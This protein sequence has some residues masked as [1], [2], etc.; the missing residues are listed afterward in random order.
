MSKDDQIDS[1]SAP[2]LYGGGNV[3]DITVCHLPYQKA[4]FVHGWIY[5]CDGRRDV[6]LR[7]D[8]LWTTAEGDD[9]NWLLLSDGFQLPQA[10]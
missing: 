1:D 4:P 7:N 8:G 6:W 10:P 9:R 3:Q 5:T 2:L